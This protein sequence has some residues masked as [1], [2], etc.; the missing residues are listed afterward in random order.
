[1]K[2]LGLRVRGTVAL[3]SLALVEVP[4]RLGLQLVSADP[5]RAFKNN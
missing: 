5:P 2:D 1:M 4:E 3:D